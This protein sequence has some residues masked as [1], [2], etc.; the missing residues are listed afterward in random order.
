[1][2]QV[3][4]HKPQPS[5]QPSILTYAITSRTISHLT[6]PALITSAVD[7]LTATIKEPPETSQ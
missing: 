5:K 3:T 1:M 6:S 7:V 2:E 4:I